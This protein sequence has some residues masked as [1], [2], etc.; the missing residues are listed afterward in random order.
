MFK[1]NEIPSR[2]KRKSLFYKFE[3]LN[4][5]DQFIGYL[6]DITLSGLKV[7]SENSMQPNSF[8]KLKIKLPPRIGRKEEITFNAECVWCKKDADDKKYQLG[9][10]AHHEN[11]D[12]KN[13]IKIIM[14]LLASPEDLIL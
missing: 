6:G 5:E 7:I 9:F 10:K 13:T 8:H 14:E 11:A 2:E 12:N 3:V 1:G 4:I